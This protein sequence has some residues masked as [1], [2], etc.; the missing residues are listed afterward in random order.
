MPA[1]KERVNM[2][3]II[4]KNLPCG[5]VFTGSLSGCLHHLNIV[6]K[7]FGFWSSV[8]RSATVKEAMDRG[9]SIIRA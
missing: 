5:V 1:N 9:F 3:H 6:L 2:Y 4:N 7:G 8:R